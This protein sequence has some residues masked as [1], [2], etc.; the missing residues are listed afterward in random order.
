MFIF[1]NKSGSVSVGE[2]FGQDRGFGNNDKNDIKE[3]IKSANSVDIR[4]IFHHYLVNI[5]YNRKCNCPFPSHKSD[6]TPS[7]Y[8]YPDTNSFF[9]F[10]CKSGGGCVNFVSIYEV[11]SKEAAA[12]KILDKFQSDGSII[13]RDPL[14]LAE[15]NKIILGFATLIRTFLRN[16]L[17]D[18]LALT[19][20]E[21]VQL[22]F[23]TITMRHQLDNAGLKSLINKLKLKLEQFGV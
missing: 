11:I 3:L 12:K 5:G 7:F 19:Y 8:Y 18:K 20:C 10:G 9:C 1:Q 4:D 2:T 17:D 16:N 23:D 21:K 6:R 14:E 13:V 15:R 22:I